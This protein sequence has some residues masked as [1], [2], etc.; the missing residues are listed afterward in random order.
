M[1]ILFSKLE[2]YVPTFGGEGK[3]NNGMDGGTTNFV[4]CLSWRV[5]PL[6]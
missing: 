2:T 5:G 1:K 6:C 3:D 4:Y